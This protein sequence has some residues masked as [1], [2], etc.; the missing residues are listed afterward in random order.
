M[1]APFTPPWARPMRRSAESTPTLRRLRTGA[2]AW[3][4]RLV[5]PALQLLMVLV[6]ATGAAAQEKTTTP[7]DTDAPAI[8]VFPESGDLRMD[9]GHRAYVDS[10]VFCDATSFDQSSIQVTFNGQDITSSFP[11]YSSGGFF[12]PQYAAVDF[13]GCASTMVKRQY[14]AG[15]VPNFR[16]G[17]NELRFH[18]CDRIYCNDA[19]FSWTYTSDIRPRVTFTEQTLSTDRTTAAVA[20]S[21]YD[22]KGLLPGTVGMTINGAP[23]AC[24]WTTGST[25][26]GT[27]RCPAVPLSVGANTLVARIDDNA[28]QT[29]TATHVVVRDHAQPQ[30]AFSPDSLR[31][32]DSLRVLQVSFSDDGLIDQASRVVRLN[33]QVI[34]DSTHWFST[35]PLRPGFNTLE[36]T[37][38]DQAG[39]CV[40]RRA[41]HIFRYTAERARPTFAAV[42]PQV[43]D[44]L[45][46]A[47]FEPRV[48]YT[49]P[50]YVSRDAPRSLTLVHS[51]HQA[52]PT[53]L[54]QA[55][56]EDHSATPPD[57]MSIRINN[58]AFT[59]NQTFTHGAVYHYYKAGNGVNRLAARLDVSHLPTGTYEFGIAIDSWWKTPTGW[60]GNEAG[61]YRVVRVIVVNERDSFVG[62]GWSVAGLQRLHVLSDTAALLTEGDGGALY[63]RKSTTNAAGEVTYR[64]PAGERSNLFWIP[65]AS[66]ARYERRY[67]DGTVA[68][69]DATGRLKSVRSRLGDSTAFVY[70]AGGK[71]SSVVDPAGQSLTLQ[72]HW[73]WGLARIIDPAGRQTTLWYGG[74]GRYA[75]THTDIHDPDGTRAL[76]AQYDSIGHLTGWHDRNGAQWS[77]A[78][79]HG[80]ESRTLT[81]PALEAGSATGPQ[82]QV[83]SYASVVYP[84]APNGPDTPAPR[85]LPEEAWVTI[86]YPGVDSVS[87]V[88]D[89]WGLPLRV[90]DEHGRD[91][92][93][94]RDHQGRDSLVITTTGD[95]TRYTYENGKL[96][97]VAGPRGTT[98]LSYGGFDQLTQVSG[99]DGSTQYHLDALGLV[100]SVVV[101]G[102]MKLAYQR[103]SRGRVKTATDGAGRVFRFAYQPGGM[104]NLD[105]VYTPTG[106]VA[107]R[108]DAAGRRDRV[109]NPRG[110]HGTVGYDAVNRA[111][112]VSDPAQNVTSLSYGLVSVDTVRDARQQ[113]HG[114]WSNLVG[115]DTVRLDPRGGRTLIRYRPDGRPHEMV[116]RRGQRVSMEYDGTGRLLRQIADVPG[117]A[118]RDTIAFSYDTVPAGRVVNLRSAA[119]MIGVDSAVNAVVVRSAAS[120]DTLYY[121]RDGR[122]I[123]QVTA[124]PGGR[125]YTLTTTFADTL[126]LP[127]WVDWEEGGVT[128]QAWEYQMVPGIGPGLMQIPRLTGVT[129]ASPSDPRVTGIEH[130]AGENRQYAPNS[131]FLSGITFTRAAANASAGVLYRYDALGRVTER[132]RAA[133]DTAWLYRYDTAG[134]IAKYGR[135]SIVPGTCGTGTYGATCQLNADSVWL[136]GYTYDAVGNATWFSDAQIETG[137]RL[138]RFGGWTMTYDAD[139][140]MTR[141]TNGVSDYR[142]HWNA[143]GQLDSV[144]I[145]DGGGARLGAVAYAYDGLGRRVRKTGPQGDIGFVYDGQ[146]V[147]MDVDPST[148]AVIT[149]YAYYPGIDQPAYLARDGQSY[150][151]LRDHQGSITALVDGAG[152]PVNRY[153]YSPY[154]SPE[155]RQEQV[156]QRYT[157]TGR[158]YESEY[159]MY[160]YRARYYD[161]MAGRFISEDPIGLG[162]GINPFA[163]VGGDPVNHT[164]PSGLC[165]RYTIYTTFY[166]QDMEVGPLGQMTPG[167]HRYV[168][169]KQESVVAACRRSGEGIT[170]YENVYQSITTYRFLRNG[171]PYL[172]SFERKDGTGPGGLAQ[173]YICAMNERHNAMQTRSLADQLNAN[174]HERADLGVYGRY[175]SGMYAKYE[176]NGPQDFAYWLTL[177][178]ID[179][180]HKL[181]TA[182]CVSD[183]KP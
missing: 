117:T 81:M 37:V 80:G 2:R 87:Y 66:P 74:T 111:A 156:P 119:S 85:V 65:G 4:R 126:M 50:S 183:L 150:T 118:R 182:L 42:Q 147:M 3:A 15:A 132:F 153:R 151:Y 143:L 47:A 64:S 43:E 6:T 78:R 39:N 79:D 92:W 83:R 7:P 165:T 82:I 112:W 94:W 136:S 41:R 52:R 10:V 54:I 171:V 63:F 19:V 60:V 71:L 95:T 172:Q 45:I 178:T 134:R 93:T 26:A 32:T 55:D 5:R 144:G 162:G 106:P 125:R 158:E 180:L 110:E 116:N 174:Y 120:T 76:R 1:S 99:N 22:D 141:K 127:K 176:H 8:L 108:Y 104:Q 72:Y 31:T 90:R 49:T 12:E 56:I 30:I 61:A 29:G 77:V 149:R 154:G 69:L 159:G 53:V 16:E 173:M 155:V 11:L 146:Q 75:L 157:Y 122:L 131:G 23:A 25:T 98:E 121:S 46:P 36:A 84:A 9:L 133:G 51:A 161:P 139:G 148:G 124:R 13:P 137:N 170:R 140:N 68:R 20:A 160:Y 166:E 97:L 102:M 107:Y 28:G 181:Q 177:T 48:T 24:T 152:T 130:S 21:F 27:L 101:P 91:G 167:E 135:A 129:Y 59:V 103:D 89:R 57:V 58:A 34:G 38:C 175:Y 114:F 113:V 163:Y 70:D 169:T 33:G 62:P 105:T 123:R 115:W 100:D 35:V 67:P 109:T 40:T 73:D 168:E 17:A 88:P 142:F 164:D 128:L 18:L 96:K 179:H 138:T 14:N 86:K 145:Y 44:Q